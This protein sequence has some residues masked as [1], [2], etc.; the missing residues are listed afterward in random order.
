MEL[1][2]FVNGTEGE[3]RERISLNVNGRRQKDFEG[4][5]GRR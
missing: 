2:Q 5:G 4:G 3:K 1:G